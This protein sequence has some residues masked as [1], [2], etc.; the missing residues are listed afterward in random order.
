M[1]VRFRY[2]EER[3]E[4][5][6][7]ALRVPGWLS[8][9]DAERIARWL[10][11]VVTVRR[12]GVADAYWRAAS[13]GRSRVLLPDTLSAWHANRALIH[14]LAHPLLDVGM[15]PIIDGMTSEER[16]GYRQARRGSQWEEE[17]ADEFVMALRLPSALVTA[18][19]DVPE[20]ARLTGLSW[21]AVARRRSVLNGQAVRLTWVPYW[22]AARAF[23][24]ERTEA[25]FQ[26]REGAALRIRAGAGPEGSRARELRL[27]ADL[28]ALRPREFLAK[29]R[30]FRVDGPPADGQPLPVEMDELRQWAG[31][32]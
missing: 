6:R 7:M 21:A 19:D 26:V 29:Y 16:A 9:R 8:T 10:R 17:L 27:K 15:G 5:C 25:G 3:A 32:R 12:C 18:V 28:A 4:A 2:L 1:V 11:P 14:E 31:M 13:A 23:T 30:A 24:L 20:I 22:S